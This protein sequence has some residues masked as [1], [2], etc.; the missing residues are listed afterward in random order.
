[1]NLV[2]ATTNP[3]KLDEWRRLLAP[4]PF[5]LRTS[6]GDAPEETGATYLENAELKAL[7]AARATGELAI[8]D[9]TGLEVDAMDGAPGIAT[10]HWVGDRGGWDHALV[11]L[12][13]H[14]GSAATL[15]CAVVVADARGVIARSE[16]RVHGRL[17]SPLTSASGP[18]AIFEPDE[19]AVIEDGVLVHRRRA[20]AA[21]EATL[22]ASS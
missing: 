21:I 7:A 16:A 4:L 22:R 5:A 3:G 15:V 18:A 6:D 17:R 10:A 9:D 8:A 19:G 1:M 2:V 11:E 13:V 14:A 12:A 20:F